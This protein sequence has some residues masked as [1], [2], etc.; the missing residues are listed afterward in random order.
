[1]NPVGFVARAVTSAVLAAAAWML[2]TWQ[3]DPFRQDWLS[4][5]LA[6]E[7]DHVPD[8]LVEVGRPSDVRVELR[9]SRNAW[10]NVRSSDFKASI[11]LSKAT[12]GIRTADVKVETSG[13][14]QIVDWD[15]RQVTVR[16][17]PVVQRTLSVQ[18]DVSGKPP[19]GYSVG[20]RSVSPD[21]ITISGQQG[22]VEA[23]SQAMVKVSIDGARGDVTDNVVPQLLDSASKPIDGLQLS[24]PTVH[25]SVSI[26]RQLQAKSVG[27][28]VPTEGQVAPGFWLSNLVANPSSVTI[29]GSPTALSK[30]DYIQLPALDLSGATGNVVRTVAL[31]NTD[32][33]SLATPTQVQVTATVTPLRTSELLPLGVTVTGL[34][35]GTQATVSPP[36]IEVSISGRA[37]DLLGLKPG[38]LS[39]VIDVGGLT[40]G[41]HTVSVRLNSPASIRI[42]TVRPDQV[43]ATLGPAVTTAA[44]PSPTPQP[45]AVPT[46]APSAQPTPASG[47]VTPAPS[48][49][50]TPSGSPGRPSPVPSPTLGAAR[51]P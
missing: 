39:A 42:D 7:V 34:V 33:Y 37:D 2:V 22:L 32:E 12:A 20:D 43:T 10:S 46:A 19:D 4:D 6:V 45:T 11:D 24:P 28:S 48:A 13:E 21:Q 17:D 1:M 51:S 15:P 47:S 23:V 26:D 41:P 44:A 9:A 8:G 38:D 29:V 40:S 18:L 35:E 14:Y 3:Q 25:L 27:I 36:S 16:L 49:S 50:A 5:R 31:N 30:V